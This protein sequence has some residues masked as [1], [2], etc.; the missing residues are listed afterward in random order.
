MAGFWARKGD[1]ARSRPRRSQ[2]QKHPSRPATATSCRKQGRWRPHSQRLASGR[3]RSQLRRA[4]PSCAPR[5]LRPLPHASAI[6]PQAAG[7]AWPAPELRS[8]V[9]PPS[10]GCPDATPSQL[11]SAQRSSGA[12]PPPLHMNCTVG[13]ARSRLAGALQTPKSLRQ[14]A[15]RLR[16]VRPGQAPAGGTRERQ[17]APV[18]RAHPSE[19]RER[20]RAG[21]AS[22]RRDV[23]L[24]TP[25]HVLILQYHP[26]SL[27]Q[28]EL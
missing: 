16:P 17:G 25:P 26:L 27:Q 23:R 24:R 6:A 8:R 1:D 19:L 13:E 2:Q 14:P 5:G 3:V 9:I 15:N 20:H 12:Q 7:G 18:R 22:V 21:E 4:G 10:T 11:P 28:Q